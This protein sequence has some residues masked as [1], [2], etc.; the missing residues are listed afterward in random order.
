MKTSNIKK[1][2]PA[3]IIVSLC[4]FVGSSFSHPLWPWFQSLT[5]DMRERRTE[6]EGERGREERVGGREGEAQGEGQWE[7]SEST[8]LAF[9]SSLNMTTNKLQPAHLNN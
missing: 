2:F 3:S 5:L 1:I 4:Y 8:F 9:V 7:I 6:E